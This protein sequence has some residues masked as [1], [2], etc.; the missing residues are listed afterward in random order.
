V[1]RFDPKRPEANLPPIGEGRLKDPLY[2][3]VDSGGNLFVTQMQ[4]WKLVKFDPDGNL[5]LDYNLPLN[6]VPNSVS[7][8]DAAVYLPIGGES[9]VLELTSYRESDFT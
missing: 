7:T 3:A 2:V 6:W 5:L 1:H 8:R 4:V 9:L